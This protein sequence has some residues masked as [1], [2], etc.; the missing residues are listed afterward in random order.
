[1]TQL[2]GT[3]SQNQRRVHLR[4]IES[5]TAADAAFVE[6][7]TCLIEP[8]PENLPEATEIE[9]TITYDEQAR[10]HVGAKVLATGQEAQTEIIR[11]ENL[12]VSALNESSEVE[13][14]VVKLVPE[15]P[16]KPIITAPPGR[17]AQ[18]VKL[19]FPISPPRDQVKPAVAVATTTPARIAKPSESL[20]SKLE[21]SN[22]P[23]PLCNQ[24]GEPIEAGGKCPRCNTPDQS[25]K[26]DPVVKKAALPAAATPR[27]AT[28]T[29]KISPP[30]APQAK[31][32]RPFLDHPSNRRPPSC[33]ATTKK[34]WALS[35][36]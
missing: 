12:V 1:M 23:I 16:A 14:A 22:R 3:V 13:D 11:P 21:D 15:S 6:L 24:C 17:S 30:T 20:L 7:G 31:A 29:K 34:F 5:G 8:L 28:G 25:A 10:V 19:D 26:T 33:P 18:P 2:Y 27:P 4:I 32:L 9:V 35:G 36:K